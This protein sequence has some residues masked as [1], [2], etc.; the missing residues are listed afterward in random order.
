[1]PQVFDRNPL[2]SHLMLISYNRFIL[3]IDRSIS[4]VPSAK[5]TNLRYH[6]QPI[7]SYMMVAIVMIVNILTL[8]ICFSQLC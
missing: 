3:Q 7:A 5:E 6:R 2:M 1:M 8:V 4:E